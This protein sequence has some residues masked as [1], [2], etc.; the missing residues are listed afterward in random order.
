MKRYLLLALLCL[1]AVSCSQETDF[2]IYPDVHLFEFDANGGSFDDVIFTNGVWSCEVS[3]AAVSVLPLSGDYTSPISVVVGENEERFTK[4]IRLRFTSKLD[5]LSRTAD[6]IITQSCHPFI[7]C[8]EPVKQV[9]PEGGVVRFSVNSNEPW[10][11][12]TPD[13]GPMPCSVD[14]MTGGPNSTVV[15][16]DVPANPQGAERTLRV[17]LSLVSDPFVFVTLTIIQGA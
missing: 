8:D 11:V 15:S 1:A 2:Y 14:P 13:G 16:V 12:E 17:V 10:S 9:G 4:V 7:F 3:D 5:E 6:I